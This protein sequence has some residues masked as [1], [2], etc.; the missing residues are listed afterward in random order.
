MGRAFCL[1]LIGFVLLPT[2]GMA[3]EDEAVRSSPETK[4]GVARNRPVPDEEITARAGDAS[5]SSRGSGA[6]VVA[7]PRPAV[8]N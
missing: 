1:L 7:R 5:A 2:W 8:L 6:A 3:V 4:Q